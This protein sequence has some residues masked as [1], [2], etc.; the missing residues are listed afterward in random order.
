MF[1]SHGQA[2]FTEPHSSSPPSIIPRR[3]TSQYTLPLL[4]FSAKVRLWWIAHVSHREK[5]HQR[6]VL[7]EPKAY[8]IPKLYYLSARTSTLTSPPQHRHTKQPPLPLLHIFL[9]LLLKVAYRQLAGRPALWGEGL[10]NGIC[11]FS[12]YYTLYISY[13]T[14]HNSKK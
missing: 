5:E 11:F 1:A 12:F 3:S 10:G 2:P 7:F 14:A 8:F 6:G 9:S 13:R 4:P